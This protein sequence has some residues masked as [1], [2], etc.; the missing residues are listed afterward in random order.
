MCVSLVKSAKEVQKKLN[1]KYGD[2]GFV[3]PAVAANKDY[4]EEDK[5]KK[6]E[7]DDKK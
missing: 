2:A 7:S 4:Q 1:E 3:D 6:K 5:D